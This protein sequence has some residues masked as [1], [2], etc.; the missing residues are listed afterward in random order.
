MQAREGNRPGWG[1]RE[2]LTLGLICEETI[3]LG[4]GS[5]ESNNSET[6]ISS[7]EDQ[8]LAHN[9]Q[10]DE[11]EISTVKHCAALSTGGVDKDVRFKSAD[12]QSHDERHPLQRG[13]CEK[14]ARKDERLR[15]YSTSFSTS[16]AQQRHCS[17][18]V[19]RIFVVGRDESAGMEG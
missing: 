10:T 14:D 5:V 16:Q 18:V 7:I 11:A 3:N 2:I 17:V 9:S 12:V 4:G 19:V 13:H 1:F 6:V 15:S 8:V